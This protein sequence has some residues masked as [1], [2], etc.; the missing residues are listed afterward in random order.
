VQIVEKV[1]TI[2]LTDWLEYEA[3][4]YVIVETGAFTNTSLSKLPYAGITTTQGWNFSIRKLVCDPMDI[5]VTVN[6]EMECSSS[7]NIDVVSAG[8]FVLTLDGDTIMAGDTVLAS[9]MYT[10]MAYNV[11]GDC[12]V[13]EEITIGSM[14][15]VRDTIV[16]AYLGEPVHFTD[17]ESGIDTMLTVGVHTMT[18]DYMECVR[19]L[20]VTVVEEIRT[21][22]IAEIQGQVDASPLEGMLVKVVATVTGVVPGEGF[23][24]QDANE[25]WSGIWVEF[26]DAS[27]EGIQIGNGVTVIGTVAEVLNVTSIVD[28]QM[29]F[30]PPMVTIETMVLASPSE[31]EAEMYESVLVKVEGARATAE[32]AV[33]GEWTVYY[34]ESDNAVVNDWL[35]DSMPVEDHFY[36]VTGIVNAKNDNFK[37]EPRI[38]SDV[39]DKTITKV[40]PIEANTFKVYPNPFNDRI[41]IDN[42]DKLTRVVVSNIAGQR[43][44]DIEYPTREIR[45]ANLVSGIYVISLYTENGVAKTERIIK[46]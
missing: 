37:L 6:D 15:V 45:T 16:E 9:G 3:S 23:F 24:M 21:P 2:T 13:T 22:T 7:V 39:K 29:S 44:I 41:T 32:D 25:A 4:Y 11:D 26:V 18:Y 5:V 33:N 12:S 14:P 46:R 35:Y 19:T 38:E 17:A 28:A 36:D 31:L 40:D 10:V 20:N 34:A 42:Y 30:T 43:V 27:Y 8:D 1:A